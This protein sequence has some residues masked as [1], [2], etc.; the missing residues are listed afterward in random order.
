MKWL[1]AVLL[2]GFTSVSMSGAETAATNNPAPV[3]ITADEAKDHVD[4]KAIV[5]GTVAEVYKSEKVVRL[6]FEKPFPK[7]PFNVVVFKDKTNLFGDLDGYK[8]KRVEVTGKITEYRG[9]PEIVLTKPDQ[10][11]TAGG[12]PEASKK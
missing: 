7:Q 6:N 10:I 1:L 8:G 4:A 2:I 12:E 3:R 11:K 9:R 5:T